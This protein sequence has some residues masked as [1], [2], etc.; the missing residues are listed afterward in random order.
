H[1]SAGMIASSTELGMGDDGTDGII[2][3]GDL[4]LDPEPGTDA[5]DVLDLHGEA[6]EINVTP[7][8]GYA[9]SMRGVAREYAHATGVPFTDPAAA[10]HPPAA[11]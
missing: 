11:D 9:F 2:V 5:R 6:A 4:G 10:I 7:D 8:R 3:L 1:V